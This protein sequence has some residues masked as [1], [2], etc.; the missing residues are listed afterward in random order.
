MLEIKLNYSKLKGM[1]LAFCKTNKKIFKEINASCVDS[2]KALGT[3]C[4]CLLSLLFP[5]HL[6]SH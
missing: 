5:L 4:Q 1:L 2:E 3:H 6:K